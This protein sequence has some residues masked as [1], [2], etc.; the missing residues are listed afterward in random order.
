MSELEIPDFDTFIGHLNSVAEKFGGEQ[1]AQELIDGVGLNIA[2]A[3]RRQERASSPTVSYAV[4]T[5]ERFRKDG[6]VTEITYDIE[7]STEVPVPELPD[8]VKAHPDFKLPD[9]A[10]TNEFYILEE[11]NFT[12]WAL[13]RKIRTRSLRTYCVATDSGGDVEEVLRAPTVAGKPIFYCRSEKELQKVSTN[14]SGG[15][16]IIEY[17]EPGNVIDD[18]SE[19]ARITAQLLPADKTEQH[20]GRMLGILSSIGQGYEK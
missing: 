10:E 6:E 1:Y 3:A 20:I 2:L 17:E 9:D 8:I 11:T 18:T 15:T 14:G 4:F 7:E 12:V 5:A 16:T 13:R 19:F